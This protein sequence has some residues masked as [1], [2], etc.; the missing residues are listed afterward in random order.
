MQRLTQTILACLLA[1]LAAP[2]AAEEKPLWELGFGF[3]TL[4]SPDYRGSDQ[5]RI[6]LLPLPY[7]IYHGEF[8]KA[9]RSG[10]YGRLFESPRVHLDLSFDGG[11]P[12]DS[13]RNEARSGMP[14]LDPVF[15]V[16]PSLEVCLW[17]NCNAD[18]VLQFRLPV[19]AVFSTNFS[20]ID[21]HGGTIYPH[22]NFDIK[23]VGPGGGWNFGVSAGPLYATEGYHDYYYRVAPQYATPTRPAYN[24]RGGYSGSRTTLALSKRFGRTWFGAFA[25][26]DDLAGAKF[27]DSPLM[28]IGHSFMA[29]FSFAWV[30]AES[31]ELVDVR[32]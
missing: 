20:S 8:L 22:L 17:H 32:D 23:N 12:V 13:S 29:G 25:R 19:R 5:S 4:T 26:Y 3:F 11:V 16:G 9:D 6:Y 1:C 30:F 15:E 28:R 27:E 24:P 18:R 7:V 10:I 31:D 14:D 2:G 21:S